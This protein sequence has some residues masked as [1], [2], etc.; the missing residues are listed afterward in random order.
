[1]EGSASQAGVQRRLVFRV[2][3]QDYEIDA[4]RV[5]EVVRVPHITR[6]PHGPE[7][8]KGIANL[9]GRPIPVLSMNRVLG[10]GEGTLREDGKIIVYYHGSAV[11]LLVDDVLRLSA[12]A[13][14]TPIQDL[15]ERLDAAFKVVRRA[16]VERASHLDIDQNEQKN[17]KLKTLL[18]FRV[19]GQLYGLPLEH[20]R[21]VSNFEG[22]LTVLPNAEDALLGLVPLRDRVV[23]LM[24]LSSIMGLDVTRTADGCSRIVIVEYQE[25]LIGLVVDQLDLIYRLPEQAIDAVPAVLQRGRGDAQIEAIGRITERSGSLIS[26]LSPEKLF[27]HHAVAQALS[28]NTGVRSMETKPGVAA[29]VEQLLIFQ[30]GDENYGLPIAS[31]DEVIRVPDEITRMPGAPAF[32]RGVI[33]LRG[34]AMPLIDQRA[35]FEIPASVHTKKV[36]AIIVTI[37]A[38]QAGFV[39]DA[40]SEVNAVPVNAVSAA[41][42]FSS[43]QT[44]IFDRIAHIEADGRMIL[45]IDPKELLTRAEQDVVAAFA[46]EKRVEANP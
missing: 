42:E 30:L 6:V 28:Q 16:P 1:M 39:V 46:A 44:D 23:P 17:F 21:E 38:L 5:T 4:G 12:D 32:V 26:I 45:L 8:L 33:N 37:G 14:A 24:A 13:T 41:P 40:V 20:I 43:Q 27:G 19:A 18:A 10:G 35:R 3:T 15:S 11:G 9:R 7:A 29:S 36:R 34:K 2:G 25:D 31:V 22:E